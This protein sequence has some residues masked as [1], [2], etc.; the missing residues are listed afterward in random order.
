VTPSFTRNSHGHGV[1][2]NVYPGETGWIIPVAISI[3]TNALLAVINV[4]RG[5]RP[6]IH[7]DIDRVGE[8]PPLSSCLKP[9][10]SSRLSFPYYTD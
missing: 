10:G 8:A 2:L 6:D 4:P 5:S 1:N 3:I 9:L 7:C